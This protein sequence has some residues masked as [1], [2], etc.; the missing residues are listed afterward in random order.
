MIGYPVSFDYILPVILA[1]KP[2][3][4]ALN[5]VGDLA[6]SLAG[7]KFNFHQFLND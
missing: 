3:E 1:D 2:L 6:L 4:A 7:F 5:M